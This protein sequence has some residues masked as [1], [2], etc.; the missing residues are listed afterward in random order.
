MFPPSPPLIKSHLQTVNLYISVEM[1]GLGWK[2][3]LVTS[4]T[5]DSVLTWKKKK[6]ECLSKGIKILR[7]CSRIAILS[8][9]K[10]DFFVW[11]IIVYLLFSWTETE[12]CFDRRVFSFKRKSVS[13]TNMKCFKCVLE[14]ST[15]LAYFRATAIQ[16]Q[17]AFKKKT[18]KFREKKSFI[19]LEF[20]FFVY[21]CNV[22]ILTNVCEW[23]WLTCI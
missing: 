12:L 9:V 22:Y 11:V 1:L 20:F 21:F 5:V 10:S 7:D 6:K 4:P 8:K 2:T 16:L 13:P 19:S 18:T 3:L 15:C 17:M 23:S 14:Y